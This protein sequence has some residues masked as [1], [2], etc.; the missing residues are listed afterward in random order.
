[1]LK[2]M[3]HFTL[4][5]T[6]ASTNEV[7]W[8]I[9]IPMPDPHPNLGLLSS[10]CCVWDGGGGWVQEEFSCFAQVTKG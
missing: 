9:Q 1:M 10:E 6:I 2:A 7:I 4:L 5:R 8:T 3:Q